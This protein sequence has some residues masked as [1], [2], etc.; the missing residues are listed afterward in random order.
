MEGSVSDEQVHRWL[1][2][3]ADAGFVSLHVD[4][5]ALGGIDRAEISGGGYR[6]FEMAWTQPANRSIWSQKDAKFT[7]LMQCRISYFGIWSQ[8]HGGLLRAYAELPKPVSIL[9][10]KG[11]VIPAGEL[12]ISLA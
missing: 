12:A 3:I 7:G 8:L 11:Y 9:N 5:P 2:N 10:G 6:R 4:T 1:Q